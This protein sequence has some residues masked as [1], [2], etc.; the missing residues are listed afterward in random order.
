VSEDGQSWVDNSPESTVTIR[1]K[2]GAVVA[3]FPAVPGATVTATRIRVNAA[4]FPVATP[5]T[6]TPTT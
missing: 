6:A 1:D 2:S 3:A 4:G 5:G